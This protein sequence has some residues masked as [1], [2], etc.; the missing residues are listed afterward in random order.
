MEAESNEHY[1]EQMGECGQ[2]EFAKGFAKQPSE[3]PGKVAKKRLVRC[4]CIIRHPPNQNRCIK[5]IIIKL[6][7]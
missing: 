1:A 4:R 7:C 6:L 2:N 5:S 3:G